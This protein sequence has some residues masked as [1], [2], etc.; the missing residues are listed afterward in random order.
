MPSAQSPFRRVRDQRKTGHSVH[1]AFLFVPAPATCTPTFPPLHRDRSG[2]AL[3]RPPQPA[4]LI[5]CF[6]SSTWPGRPAEWL[7]TKARHD[8]PLLVHCSAT[9][10][11]NRNPESELRPYRSEEHTSELQSLR[12]LVC[13]LL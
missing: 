5:R 1:P 11:P 10:S 7:P 8:Q 6:E 2:S 13:R 4:L 12:H 9:A 3:A